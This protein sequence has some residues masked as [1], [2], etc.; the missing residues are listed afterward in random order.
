MK[1]LSI[2]LMVSTGF[3]FLMFIM[4]YIEHRVDKMNENKF[5]RWWRMHIIGKF[6]EKK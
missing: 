6:P 5:T 1:I 2:Y 4:F 3:I